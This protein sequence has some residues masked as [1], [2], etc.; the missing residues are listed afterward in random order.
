M[1]PDSKIVFGGDLLFHDMLPT[2]I[3]ASTQA[4]IDTLDLL[5]ARHADYTF[6]PGHGDVGQAKDVAAFREY[7]LTLRRLVK[8]RGLR[9]GLVMQSPQP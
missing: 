1:I 3:D 6:V 8:R 4:W 5:L 9:D 7:L 2:L